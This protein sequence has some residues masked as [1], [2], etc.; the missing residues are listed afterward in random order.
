MVSTASGCPL[1]PAWEVA[2]GPPLGPS[3]AEESPPLEEV[4]PFD[5]TNLSLSFIALPLPLPLA[6][7]YGTRRTPPPHTLGA[8]LRRLAREGGKGGGGLRRRAVVQVG[9]P[10]R[11]VAV[12]AYCRALHPS[13]RRLTSASIGAQ[14]LLVFGGDEGIGVTIGPPLPPPAPEVFRRKLHPHRNL[15]G[16]QFIELQCIPRPRTGVKGGR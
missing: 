10:R 16:R 8:V 5:V 9:R 1:V 11:S 6:G 12:A 15:A 13:L 7:A 4:E 14:G 3:P 2:R